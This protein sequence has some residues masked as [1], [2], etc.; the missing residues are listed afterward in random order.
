MRVSE[1]S[2]GL[3]YTHTAGFE[4]KDSMFKCTGCVLQRI[5]NGGYELPKALH[6]QCVPNWLTN[7][8]RYYASFPQQNGEV[9]SARPW[10]YHHYRY[11]YP[12]LLEDAANH[13]IIE[14]KTDN[15]GW[16]PEAVWGV[17]LYW[18]LTWAQPLAVKL[19][20]KK[21]LVRIVKGCKTSIFFI[22]T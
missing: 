4:G 14:W 18:V 11:I 12:N 21:K 17:V 15:V 13:L 8:Q 16:K 19:W 10:Y 5:M 20:I 1:C 9:A 6:V 2:T 7:L 3:S 22:A